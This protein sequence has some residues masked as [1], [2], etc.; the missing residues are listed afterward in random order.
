MDLWSKLNEPN[1]VNISLDLGDVGKKALIFSGISAGLVA[2]YY[3]GKKRGESLIGPQRT[4]DEEVGKG[5]L[6][7]GLTW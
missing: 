5:L 2:A 6:F 4:T 3:M 1:I 7:E